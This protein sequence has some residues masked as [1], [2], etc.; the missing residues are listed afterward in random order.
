MFLS[1]KEI[2]QLT[3][4]QKP[5]VQAR[6]FEQAGLPFLNGGDGKVK[7]RRL[8]VEQRLGLGLGT[9]QPPRREPQLRL[10]DKQRGKN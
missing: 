4:Y 8:A 5:Y 6:W 2:E 9:S 3:G 10:V 1:S 7:V